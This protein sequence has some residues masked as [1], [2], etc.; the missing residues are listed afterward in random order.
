MILIYG[1]KKYTIACKYYLH[2]GHGKT[3]ESTVRKRE[4]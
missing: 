4:V 2:E 3:N 1:D